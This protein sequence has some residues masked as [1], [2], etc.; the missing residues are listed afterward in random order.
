MREGR[1]LRVGIDSSDGDYGPIF[2]DGRFEFI[3]IV[4]WEQAKTEKYCEHKVIEKN[5]EFDSRWSCFL[6]PQLANKKVH[7][8]P[9]FDGSWTYGEGPSYKSL[10]NHKPTAKMSALERLKPDDL[11]VFTAGL[12]NWPAAPMDTHQRAC[13]HIFIVGYF[14]VQESI[15]FYRL[16]EDQIKEYMQKYGDRLSKNAHVIQHD[17]CPLLASYKK[18][19]I[20]VG[21]KYPESQLLTYAIRISELGKDVAGRDLK[22]VGK[23]VIGHDGNKKDWT[24][25]LGFCGSVQRST[26]RKIPSENIEKLE[27]E[28][29]IAL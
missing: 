20:V 25:I 6:K 19:V 18:S 2:E 23:N 12:K 24:Q 14:R 26:P 27:E 7:N 17:S 22:V 29:K 9:I 5:R 21:M 15:P 8:D 10:Q 11:L 28:L 13:A 4:G 16:K 3:P 1:L